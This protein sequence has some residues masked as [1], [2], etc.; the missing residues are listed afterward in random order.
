MTRVLR[1]GGG[2]GERLAAYPR[3]DDGAIQAKLG[4]L[5]ADDAAEARRRRE[6]QRRG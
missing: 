1:G 2:S 3:G 4:E 5:V 6:R